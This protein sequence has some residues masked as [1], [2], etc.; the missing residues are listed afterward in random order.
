MTPDAMA[1]A[2]ELRVLTDYARHMQQGI[3]HLPEEY[4]R[5]A[6]ELFEQRSSVLRERIALGSH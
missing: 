4:A 5:A 2:E 1:A 6:V 3:V